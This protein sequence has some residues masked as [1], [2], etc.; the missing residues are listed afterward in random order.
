MVKFILALGYAAIFVAILEILLPVLMVVKLRKH[1]T[2]RSTYRV[3]GGKFLLSLTFIA[4]L[5]I[6]SIQIIAYSI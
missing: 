3:L 6:I 5:L 4:G 1:P 2:L